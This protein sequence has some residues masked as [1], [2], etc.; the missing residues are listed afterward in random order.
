MYCQVKI[1]NAKYIFKGAKKLY[2]QNN[3]YPYTIIQPLKIKYF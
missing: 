3:R 1:R 2:F